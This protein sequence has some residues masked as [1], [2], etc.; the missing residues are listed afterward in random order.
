[1]P[2]KCNLNRFRD[3]SVFL[4]HH[5]LRLPRIPCVPPEYHDPLMKNA[6][7]SSIN[8]YRR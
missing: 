4:I 6:F 8:Y 5:S 1:M 2:P 3:F 7:Q